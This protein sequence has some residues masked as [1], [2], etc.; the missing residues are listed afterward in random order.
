MTSVEQNPR[1]NLVLVKDM[2]PMN[3]NFDCEV[4]VLQKGI[5]NKLNNIEFGF[6][7]HILL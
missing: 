2:N 3:R 1:V 6:S 5:M 4:I 7:D